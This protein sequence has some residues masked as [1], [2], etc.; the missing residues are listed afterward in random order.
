MVR[1]E[2]VPAVTVVLDPEVG[3]AEPPTTAQANVPP[4]GLPVTLY[5]PVK[6]A[7]IASGPVIL[8]VG[9][10]FTVT[11]FVQVLTQPSLV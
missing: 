7:Q 4:V 10:G 11:V 5:W 8:Q 3:L 2:P 6:P 9:I 1:L